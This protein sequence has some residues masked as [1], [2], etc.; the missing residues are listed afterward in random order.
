MAEF[1][2][3]KNGKVYPISKSKKKARYKNIPEEKIWN[4]QTG[5]NIWRHPSGLFIKVKQTSH[6]YQEDWDPTWSVLVSEKGYVEEWS[7]YHNQSDAVES[8]KKLME[9]SPSEIRKLNGL[10]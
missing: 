6:M 1:R 5:K 7:S 10:D 8:A 4:K 2:T 3:K 9:K